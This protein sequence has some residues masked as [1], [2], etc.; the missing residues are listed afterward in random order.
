MRTDAVAANVREIA[1][2]FA[3]DRGERQQR[4]ALDRAD[5][6]RLAQ[7]GFLLTGVPTSEGGLW[8]SAQKSTRLICELVRAL[9]GGDSS[10]ALVSSMHPA[11]L[12]FWLASPRAVGGDQPAWDRQRAEVFGTALDGQWWG[13]ITSEPGSGGDIA[14]TKTLAKLDSTGGY[15]LSG[16]KH[17]GSGS[18]IS[19]FMIT[20]ALPEGESAPD[21]FYFDARGRAWDGSAGMKLIAE[22]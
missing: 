21:L 16:Q 11:V 5:F 4:R 6:D 12:A 2:A 10:V 19:S 1:A 9:A 15:L 3:R 13:T 22:W 8:E 17:F 18:G 20:T 14:K 7:A